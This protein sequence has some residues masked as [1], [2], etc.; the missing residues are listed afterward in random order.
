VE[1]VVKE[2]RENEIKEEKSLKKKRKEEVRAEK[3]LKEKD[4]AKES[5]IEL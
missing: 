4:E 2:K 1:L 3:T 5:L